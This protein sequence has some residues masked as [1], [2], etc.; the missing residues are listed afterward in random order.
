MRRF[1]MCAAVV[2][3]MALAM[4]LAGCSDREGTLDPSGLT[5]VNLSKQNPDPGPGEG[6]PMNL[7]F[8]VIWAHPDSDTLLAP[9][10]NKVESITKVYTGSYPGVDDVQWLIENGPWYPQPPYADENTW[11]ADYLISDEMHDILF[12]DWG[13]P[14]ENIYPR[15]GQRFPVEVALFERIGHAE[16]DELGEVI[17]FAGTTMEG[18]KMACLEYDSSRDEL[19]GTN[20]VKYASC[21][22]TVLT[23]EFTVTVRPPDTWQEYEIRLDPAVGPSGK[24]NFASANG[25]WIPEV[26]GWHRITLTINDP[27]INLANA[28]VENDEHFDLLTGQQIDELSPNKKELSGVYYNTTYIDIYVMPASGGKLKPM[29]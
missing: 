9:Y 4:I 10:I 19:F 13:N 22:A 17:G 24:M 5:E 28:V 18:F 27:N 23:S 15:I 6:L 20:K 1:V 26:A 21:F 3:V 7:S 11:V 16:F 12:V 2:C 25:G 29:P 14:M 8:P